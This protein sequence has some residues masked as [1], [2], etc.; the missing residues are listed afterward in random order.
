MCGLAQI[1][2]DDTA[3]QFAGSD[4]TPFAAAKLWRE[5]AIRCGPA[6]TPAT[7]SRPANRAKYN[8]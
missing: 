3:Q 6:T 4:A 7:S 1:P 5:N 2:A 8:S